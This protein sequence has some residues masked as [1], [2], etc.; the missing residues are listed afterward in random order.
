LNAGEIWQ[1][2]DFFGQGAVRPLHNLF[3]AFG[4]CSVGHEANFTTVTRHDYGP[5]ADWLES[6]RSPGDNFCKIA[7]GL[8]RSQD[9]PT[10]ENL[11]LA[12]ELIR[13]RVVAVAAADFQALAEG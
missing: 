7:V 6:Q 9:F 12:P 5:R 1:A 13:G 11:G 4:I 2:F 10:S 8:M 3:K